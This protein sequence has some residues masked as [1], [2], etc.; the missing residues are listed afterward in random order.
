[1]EA[2]VKANRRIPPGKAVLF[3]RSGKAFREAEGRR[4]EGE[5]YMRPLLLTRRIS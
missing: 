4:V 2:S 5:F 1:M 3:G